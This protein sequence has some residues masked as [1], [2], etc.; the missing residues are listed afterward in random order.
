MMPADS[1]TLR[2]PPL[3]RGVLRRRYKRFLADIRLD[4]GETVVAHCPNSGRMTGCAEPGQPVFL[5]RHDHPKRKL[6]YTWELIEMPDSLVGVNTQVPNRLVAESIRQ[7]CIPELDGYDQIRREVRVG[8]GSRID[9]MLNRRNGDSCLVE[10]KN[11]TWVRDGVA[12]FPDAVTLRGQKHL[13]EL[14]R[15]AENGVR[16]VSFHL[17]Q[18]MDAEAFA[19]ADDIDPEYGRLLRQIQGNVVEVLAYDVR[20]DTRGVSIRN[21]LPC[22]FRAPAP[23]KK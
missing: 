1:H 10:I 4:T 22:R 7:G 2:W 18:R 13:V 8:D 12:A 21:R 23:A 17:I 9:L 20:M 6:K 15:Q 5:S 19:P 3:H 14:S 16:C 11:C